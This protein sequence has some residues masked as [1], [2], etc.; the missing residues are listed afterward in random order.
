MLAAAAQ[1]PAESRSAPRRCGYGRRRR[2]AGRRFRSTPERCARVPPRRPAAAPIRSAPARSADGRPS[3]RRARRSRSAPESCIDMTLNRFFLLPRTGGRRPPRQPPDTP[4]R[5]EAGRLPASPRPH[6][7]ASRPLLRR[8]ATGR[9]P[10]PGRGRLSWRHTRTK[11]GVPGTDRS[12]QRVARPGRKD[13]RIVA[14]RR[15]P[16]DSPGREAQ[17]PR[18]QPIDLA[19]RPRSGPPPRAAARTHGDRGR[20]PARAARNPPLGR[21]P[22]YM[23]LRPCGALRLMAR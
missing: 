10:P 14:H 16:Q 7:T 3:R 22:K 19:Q 18:R 9:S 21:R 6:L 23:R 20:R 8:S 11:A 1:P 12:P 4:R 2:P 17:F 15:A 5:S 13:R